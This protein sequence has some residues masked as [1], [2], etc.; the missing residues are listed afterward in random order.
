MIEKI[1]PYSSKIGPLNENIIVEIPKA[2]SLLTISSLLEDKN[3][4][5]NKYYFIFYSYF[6]G[7][8][9]LL[10]AG[11]Y[12]FSKNISQK[13]VLK[14]LYKNDIKLYKLVIPECYSNKQIFEIVKK[15]INI[16]ASQTS[17]TEGSLF[18]STYFYSKDT[19]GDKL[20]SIMHNQANINFSNIYKKYK[21]SKSTTLNQNEVLILASIVEAEAKIKEDQS[22]IEEGNE[23]TIRPYCYLWY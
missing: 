15:N 20:I 19:N 14:K 10:K 21:N 4:I 7:K 18:P 12:Y 2:S 22:K 5:E 1:A 13:N 16:A 8:A 9:K 17:Y 3:V 11:E 6:T 23:I